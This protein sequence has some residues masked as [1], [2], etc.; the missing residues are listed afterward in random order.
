MQL[1]LIFVLHHRGSVS[2]FLFS[3]PGVLFVLTYSP[4]YVHL[5]HIIHEDTF[6]IL[7][8]YCMP[9]CNVKFYS[10]IF[11]LIRFRFILSDT[12]LIIPS[13]LH[14]VNKKNKKSFILDAFSEVEWEDMVPGYTVN[15][16]WLLHCAT[17]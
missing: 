9:M 7:T 14:Y 16:T 17:G 11:L 3:D 4:I 8:I 5:V 13:L 6:G 15:S 1:P 2:F 10:T 12:I